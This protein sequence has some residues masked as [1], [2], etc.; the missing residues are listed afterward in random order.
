MKKMTITLAVLAVA[1]GLGAADVAETARALVGQAVPQTMV[2][3]GA[4]G[5]LYSKNELQ[6]LAKGGLTGGRVAEVA[7]CAKK[8]NADPAAA[9]AD[10]DRQ[11]KALGIQLILVPVPPKSAWR[12]P[13]GL[14]PGA[15]MSYLQPYYEELRGR[16]LD[17]LDLSGLYLKNPAP[18]VYCKTDAHWSPAGIALAVAAVREKIH[19]EGGEPYETAVSTVT[20][21]GDLAKSLNPAAPATES[22]ELRTVTGKCFDDASP[23]LVLGDSHTLVFSTGKDMLAEN[24]GFCEQLA[25]A[26]KMPVERI[27]V[28]GSAATAVRVNLY[29]KS[30]KNPAWLKNKKFVVYVFSCREFTEASSGWVKVPVMKK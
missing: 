25:W 16:G 9:L 28:K 19:L 27:G 3:R 14:A 12:P 24:G 11:L 17:V 21:A 6:H 22:L 7:A 5:W 20:V 15:A 18:D 23:V 1:G 30:A 2:C 4:D 29:R 26:L 10:F 13:E 8:A